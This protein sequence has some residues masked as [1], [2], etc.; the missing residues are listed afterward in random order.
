MLF[1]LKKNVLLHIPNFNILGK[2]ENNLKFHFNRSPVDG[3]W[4][5]YTVCANHQFTYHDPKHDTG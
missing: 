4:G 1:C 5:P 3:L 2:M